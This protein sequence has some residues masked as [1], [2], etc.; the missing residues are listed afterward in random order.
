MTRPILVGGPQRMMSDHQLRATHQTS[1]QQIARLSATTQALFFL[2]RTGSPFFERKVR[3]KVKLRIT[4]PP[5]FD[6]PT[7]A[8]RENG[9]YGGRRQSRQA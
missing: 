3:T 4:S 2:R 7:N 8:V 1:Y 6:S 5:G 9:T